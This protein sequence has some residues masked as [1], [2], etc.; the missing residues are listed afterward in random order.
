MYGELR[1]TIEAIVESIKSTFGQDVEYK[2]EFGIRTIHVNEKDVHEVIRK[3]KNEFDFEYLADV[4][5]SHWPNNE[6]KFEVSYNL[7]SV[8][9]KIRLFINT[10]LS[11][12]KVPTVTD[13]YYSADFL[14]REQYDLV[15]VVF[16]GHYNLK[17]VLL[18]EFFT[19]H[20]LQKDFGHKDRAWFN[21]A[22]E[23]NLGISFKYIGE[24]YVAPA[25]K[26][27]PVPKPVSPAGEKPVTQASGSTES[28][29][30]KT[31]N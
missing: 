8:K 29:E 16:E 17:R 6:H 19:E 9:S 21:D 23:Q 18:P 5:A 27:A 11:G 31:E 26:P 2:E 28:T 22:D 13:M 25:P 12:L 3:L 20:P 10:K 1:M 14:E 30:P 4:V 7:F 15:G 24:P